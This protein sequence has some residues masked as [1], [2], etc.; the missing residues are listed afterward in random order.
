MKPRA[1]ALLAALLLCLA[2]LPMT[3]SAQVDPIQNDFAY[4]VEYDW[5]SLDE[6][7]DSLTGINLN[8]ILSR[9]ML[10]ATD[11]GLNLTVAQLS[12]GS[13]NIF[14]APAAALKEE[15]KKSGGLF[16]GASSLFGGGGSLFGGKKEE[17][18]KEEPKK[19]DSP[20]AAP[21]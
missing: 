19:A 9:T 7:I 1:N 8:E 12:T 20:K 4:G 2:T 10:A 6:D 14:G 17:P 5:S 13:S 15:E 16:G 3:V 21:A 11:A 18:K